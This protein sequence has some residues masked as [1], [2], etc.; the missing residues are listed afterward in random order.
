MTGPDPKR[1]EARLSA[2]QA[3][4]EGPIEVCKCKDPNALAK[5]DIFFDPVGSATPGELIACRDYEYAREYPG[6]VDVLAEIRG[7]LNE[8][9]ARIGTPR[10]LQQHIVLGEA[11]SQ[12]LVDYRHCLV[13]L[14]LVPFCPKKPWQTLSRE[15]KR[16]IQEALEQVKSALVSFASSV[17]G[18][19]GRACICE[20]GP[21]LGSL[22]E[23]KDK[24]VREQPF[25]HERMILGYIAVDPFRSKS[26][27]LRA[28]ERFITPHLIK[29]DRS[30]RTT[31]LAR[32]IREQLD[33]LGVLRTDFHYPPFEDARTEYN[34]DRRGRGKYTSRKNWGLAVVNAVDVFNAVC[35]ELGIPSHALA[36]GFATPAN[37]LP[38][39]KA[40]RFSQN[41]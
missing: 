29:S 30:K 31:K 35:G 6:I 8:T 25:A 36:S 20:L 4:R 18:A 40:K 19:P 26:Q 37:P 22:N 12:E 9:Q 10:C 33:W 21:S 13:G 17:V 38:K 23:F 39:G 3:L 16:K 32:P 1:R 2:L 7:R 27:I 15:E 5:E 34:K 14:A 28:V 11:F 24:V 41:G